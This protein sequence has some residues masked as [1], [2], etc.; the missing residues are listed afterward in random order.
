MY[1]IFFNEFIVILRINHVV[2]TLDLNLQFKTASYGATL[3]HS[4]ELKVKRI[5][6]IKI[7]K[8]Q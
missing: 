2:K 7:L 3:Q 8:K 1:F 5:R 6:N 4:K